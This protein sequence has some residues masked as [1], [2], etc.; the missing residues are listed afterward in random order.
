MKKS[1]ELVEFVE[2]QSAHKKLAVKVESLEYER[3]AYKL[4]L[5]RVFE[6]EQAAQNKGPTVASPVKSVTIVTDFVKANQEL[7]ALNKELLKKVSSFESVEKEYRESE[8]NHA[9][10]LE[11][12]RAHARHL[13][14][15]LEAAQLAVAAADEDVAFQRERIEQ[16]E[17]EI[18]EIRRRGGR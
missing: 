4:E 6:A 9:K 11:D 5:M 3:E 17:R 13:S 16:L 14:A 12:E 18:L 2:L 8:D 7:Q 10:V 15:A 1:A